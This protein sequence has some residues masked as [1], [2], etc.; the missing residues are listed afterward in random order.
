MVRVRKLE[1]SFEGRE[2]ASLLHALTQHENYW[3][4][5]VLSADH[6]EGKA[7]SQEMVLTWRAARRLRIRIEQEIEAGPLAEISQGP[8]SMDIY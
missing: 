6:I 7:V 4:A 8:T 2:V 1:T 5:L 3:S